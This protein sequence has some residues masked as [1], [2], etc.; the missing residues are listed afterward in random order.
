MMHKR[1]P[2]QLG[3][4]LNT[5]LADRG[6]L[7]ACKEAEVIQKWPEIVGERLVD[8]CKCTDVRD[9]IVYVRVPSAAWRQEVSYLKKQIMN[10][11]KRICRCKTIRDIV[12]Y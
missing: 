7:T 3:S 12:F 9:G 8:V 2:Q 4:I 11:I 1:K 5:F 10:Q 6:Y